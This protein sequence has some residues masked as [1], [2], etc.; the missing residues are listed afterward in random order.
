M[1]KPLRTTRRAPLCAA[2]LAIVVMM[3]SGCAHAQQTPKQPKPLPAPA[4]FL[5]PISSL[6]IPVLPVTY[7]V[8]DSSVP[9]LP[10]SR[11]A[12]LAWADSVIADGLAEHGPEAHWI[13]P[14]E[15]RRVTRHA[16]GMV[17]DPDHMTQAVMRLTNLSKV[18]DPLL[19]NL[20]M[21]IALTGSRVVFIP[22]A[23]RF[24]MVPEGVKVEATL[25]LADARS[26]QV[27]WRSN[28]VATAP[29][30]AAALA[31]TIAR[32]LPD[33]H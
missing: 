7:L 12:Q 4:L 22:A 5:A 30:A 24:T 29:T 25:V 31:A 18:P 32:I 2:T 3:S 28:P 11:S 17:A 6:P 21:L 14:A 19:A 8:S 20:R 27:P 26:G 23:L 9:G 13:L 1:N 33:L 16:P 10:A 15:L